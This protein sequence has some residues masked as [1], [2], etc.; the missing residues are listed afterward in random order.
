MERKNHG[1]CT[2]KCAKL[3]VGILTLTPKASHFY[4][5]LA[6]TDF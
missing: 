5:P 4:Q 6:D 1:D 3:L 2:D